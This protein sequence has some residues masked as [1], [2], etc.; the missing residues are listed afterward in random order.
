MPGDRGV[1]VVLD[2][3]VAHLVLAKPPVNAFDDAFLE[4]ISDAVLGLPEAEVRALVVSSSVERVFA[5]GGDIPW[6]ASAPLADQLAFVERCQAT[7]SLFE[8]VAYPTIAAIEGAA[9]GGGFELSLA[10]D[11]RVVGPGAVLGAPEATIGLIAGAGGITRLVRAVGRGVAHD[12]LL[13]GR[14]VSAEEALRMN[15][16]SRLVGAGEALG[17][18]LELARRLADGPCE[19]IFATKR[20]A[21]VAGEGSIADGLARERE[22]WARVRV[23]ARTQE[24]LDA[25]AQKR[26]PDFR[27]VA[28][29][30]AASDA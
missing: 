15:V 8:E 30:A 27:A 18:A 7:Y 3:G 13:T 6:M 29:P 1:D 11:L 16:V 10:C 5:A 17:L 26:R 23:S 20:L 14:R 9:L 2:D 25:F 4:A 21:V 28:Q 12:L 22:A 19:A 24:G